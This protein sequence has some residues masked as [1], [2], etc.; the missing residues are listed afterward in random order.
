MVQTKI[1]IRAAPTTDIYSRRFGKAIDRALPI[2][3]ETEAP[4]LVLKDETGADLITKT[5]FTHVQIV[6]LSEGK[7]TIQFAPSSYKETGYFW[8][9]EIL[10]NDKSL[11]EQTDLCRETPYTAT[12]EVVKPPPTLAETISSMIG[13]MTGLMMLMMVVSLMGGIMSAM[14][15]K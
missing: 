15:R 13:T 1:E 6:D 2:R 9:A 14:K 5:A 10:V 7:H 4:E 11:G 8:K 12:F 3:F